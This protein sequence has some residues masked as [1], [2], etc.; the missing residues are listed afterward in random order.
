[1]TYHW[2]RAVGVFVV[3]VAT[4]Y[5]ASLWHFNQVD[6]IL[7]S[8]FFVWLHMEMVGPFMTSREEDDN[9]KSNNRK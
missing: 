7:I 1:M 4:Q 8:S 5:A 2:G 3:V 6:R 9:A